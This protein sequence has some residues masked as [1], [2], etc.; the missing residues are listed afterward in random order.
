MNNF[1]VVIKSFKGKYASFG[2]LISYTY[3][4]MIKVF[5]DI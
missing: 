5:F 3:H 1:P 4:M 2:K